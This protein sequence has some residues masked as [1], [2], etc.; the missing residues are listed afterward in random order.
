MNTDPII[1]VID[2]GT[3]SSRAVLMD[4]SANIIALSSTPI[5]QIYPKSGWV[6]H[7]A[8][9]IWESVKTTVLNLK[10]EHPNHFSRIASIGITNQRE[11]TV[12]W[13][14]SSG[15]PLHNAIVWQDTRTSDYC[16]DNIHL[17]NK[18]RMKTGL[19]LN[20][21]FSATKIRW[22]LNT[23]DPH[24]TLCN[25]NKIIAGTIDTY[26]IWNLT[27][28][29]SFYTDH[30]NGSRTLLMNIHTGNWDDE[31]LSDFNIP[32]NI[33]PEIKPSVFNFGSTSGLDFLPDGIPI[34]GVAG[35]QQA[36][37]VGHRCHSP[38]QAKCTFGTGAFLLSHTG[39]HPI[40]SD[41]GLLTTMAATTGNKLQYCLEG[42]VFIAGA[43]VQW[44]RD[45][46]GLF[47]KASE[48]EILSLES[49]LNADVVFIPALSGLGCPYWNS[50]FQGTILGLT[51]KTTKK[52]IARAALEGVAH[53]VADLLD[54][55]F[56]NCSN[57]LK[58]L[59]TDGGMTENKYFNDL[60]AKTT[61]VIIQTST[62]SEMTSIGAGIL[63]GLGSG[64]MKLNDYNSPI[65]Q[66]GK[67]YEPNLTSEMRNNKRNR[68]KKAI[69]ALE[70]FYKP[71]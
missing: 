21:Y 40:K 30:T 16:K 42:S 56:T 62:N 7:N 15:K 18:I 71:N 43:A 50:D 35:D 47:E 11:T 69:L 4:C 19:L 44:L 61:G 12:V 29:K 54:A 55:I 59:A 31:L 37:L 33:L 24:R 27:G 9:Q 20:P 52:E 32:K 26:L 1:L 60:L 63:A 2:Q 8:E 64:F 17:D 36:S 66:E 58:I 13:D 3:T 65:K 6:E 41:T 39:D 57:P 34:M 38:G 10:N 70:V 68:W 45:G 67:T 5:Q 49:D 51:R 22:I 25:D 23:Y 28:R 46:L 14:N 48:S 53:Q